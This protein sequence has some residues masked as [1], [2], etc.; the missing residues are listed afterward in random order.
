MSRDHPLINQKTTI[1]N[2]SDQLSAIQ[3]PSNLL[4]HK[5][6]EHFEIQQTLSSITVSKGGHY[7]ITNSSKTI[8]ALNTPN[9][10]RCQMLSWITVIIELI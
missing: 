10:I 2:Y 9:L 8:S 6:F 4:Y 3:K 7:C 5:K 1:M